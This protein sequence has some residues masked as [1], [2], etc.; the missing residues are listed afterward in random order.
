MLNIDI[1]GAKHERTMKGL[2][3][4]M[5]IRKGSDYIYDINSGLTIPLQDNSV[6]NWYMSMT[7]EHIIPSLTIFVLQELRRTLKPKGLIRVIVPNGMTA[8]KWFIK[9]RKKLRQK[10]NPSKPAF[11][12]DTDMSRLFSWFYTPD[13]GKKS[14]HKNA[15]DEETLLWYMKKA[16]FR[17]IK[18]MKYNQCSEIF[19]GKDYERYKDYSLYVEAKK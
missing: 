14:G 6:D 9:D 8:I 12:P 19:K 11:F 2:W 1:G 7:I 13:R 16:G 18:L 15:F 10:G 5:D 4:I 3:K 17:K